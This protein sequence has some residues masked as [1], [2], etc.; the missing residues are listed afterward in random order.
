MMYNKQWT[1]QKRLGF[2]ARFSTKLN[3][4][5]VKK[6]QISSFYLKTLSF[7]VSNKKSTSVRVKFRTSSRSTT[8]R[9]FIRMPN[10]TRMSRR[11]FFM[12]HWSSSIWGPQIGGGALRKIGDEW[13]SVWWRNQRRKNVGN[14]LSF[15]FFCFF[16]KLKLVRHRDNISVKTTLQLSDLRRAALFF[17]Q[18]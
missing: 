2:V 10:S 4:L 3:N 1:L 18:L 6:F 17:E 9:R 5:L 13:R 12:T 16:N 8:P 14:S 7:G 11:H 15:L